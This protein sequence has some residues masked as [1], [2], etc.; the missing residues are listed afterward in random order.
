MEKYWFQ[1]NQYRNVQTCKKSLLDV[2]NVIL[3][4][5]YYYTAKTRALYESTNGP[6]A[7]PADNPPNS[8]GLWDAHWTVPELIVRVYWRPGLPIWKQV[9]SNPYPDPKPQ[10]GTVANTNYT[11][12][13]WD[14]AKSHSNK[15]C[16]N[17]S[18]VLGIEWAAA[19]ICTGCRTGA[20]Q[21]STHMA[22]EH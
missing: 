19:G 21:S 20:K 4:T 17:N 13:G 1:N 7:Q 9:S 11:Q 5:Y 18:E 22:I 15:P 3:I 6:A 8:D 12:S 16:G 10:S 14:R 2:E